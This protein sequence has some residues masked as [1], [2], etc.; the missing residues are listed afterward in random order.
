MS[1]EKESMDLLENVER[2]NS[3]EENVERR[4]RKPPYTGIFFSFDV[5][6]L[7]IYPF[8]IFHQ[9]RKH[10]TNYASKKVVLYHVV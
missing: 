3:E 5:F 10:I 2:E 7:D 4:K 9:F 6:L 8:D 1:Y